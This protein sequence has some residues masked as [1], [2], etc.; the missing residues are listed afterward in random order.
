[1]KGANGMDQRVVSPMGVVTGLGKC[2][3]G[4]VKYEKGGE[5]VGYERLSTVIFL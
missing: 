4:R 1:M 3:R 2:E 5:R